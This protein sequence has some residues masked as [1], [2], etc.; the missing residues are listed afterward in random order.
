M[1]NLHKI[2]NVLFFSDLTFVCV[3]LVFVIYVT[4][5]VTCNIA[6]YQNLYFFVQNFYTKYG[7]GLCAVSSQVLLFMPAIEGMHVTSW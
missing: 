2:C 6:K 3:G 1:N 7:L 4:G 5:S